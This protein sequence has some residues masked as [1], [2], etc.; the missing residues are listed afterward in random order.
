MTK[1]IKL[2]SAADLV[3]EMREYMDHKSNLTATDEQ[4]EKAKFLLFYMLDKFDAVDQEIRDTHKCGR[5]Y[6]HEKLEVMARLMKE[7][8]SFQEFEETL[9]CCDEEEIQDLVNAHYE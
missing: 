7:F 5:P 3:G 1:D 8:K 9:W 4:K 6:L 2:V